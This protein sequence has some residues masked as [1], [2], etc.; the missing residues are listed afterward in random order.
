M[1]VFASNELDW[2]GNNLCLIGRKTPIVSIE[3][4]KTYPNMWRVR[5][6]DGRL[7]DMVNLTRARDAARG[8]ALSILN[9]QERRQAEARAR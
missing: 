7:T 9:S 3:Q 5:F 8:A 2:Q 6:P 1:R 4:D